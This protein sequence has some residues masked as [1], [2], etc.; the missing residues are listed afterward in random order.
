LHAKLDAQIAVDKAVDNRLIG[1]EGLPEVD[2]K[3]LQE[4]AVA[5]VKETVEEI[6]N[7]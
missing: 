5:Q 3:H 4:E 7:E 2:I 1:S 6:V